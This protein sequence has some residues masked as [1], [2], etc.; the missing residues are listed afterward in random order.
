MTKKRK[1]TKM[2]KRYITKQAIDEMERATLLAELSSRLPDNP[3]G[4]L[5]SQTLAEQSTPFLRA[6]LES[7]RQHEARRAERRK[8]QHNL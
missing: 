8:Q 6:A 1:D 7:V 5:Q 2:Q 4:D 3:S